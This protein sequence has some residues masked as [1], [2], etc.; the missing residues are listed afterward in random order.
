MIFKSALPDIEIP[1]VGVYQFVTRNPN[2]IKDDKVVFTDGT[3][4]EKL[5]YG[6][7]KSN[8]K[9]FAAG[10]IDKAGFKR[11]DV[12]A[13]FSPNQ[14]LSMIHGAVNSSV[15]VTNNIFF[16]ILLDRL[17]NRFIWSNYSR[18]NRN[19]C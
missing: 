2:G 4:D 6:E 17:C 8:S 1:L 12:L 19:F 14:V 15:T 11:G 16:F 7:L 3:T 5:T 10:L 18:R 13:V 9:K